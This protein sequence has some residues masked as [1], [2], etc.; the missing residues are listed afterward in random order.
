[1]DINLIRIEDM[2]HGLGCGY[3]LI[4]LLLERCCNL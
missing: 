3:E 4:I 2:H 1:M